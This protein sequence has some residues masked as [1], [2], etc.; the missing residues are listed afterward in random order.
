MLYLRQVGA[1]P[2]ILQLGFAALLALWRGGARFGGV[3]EAPEPPPAGTASFVAA[4]GRLFARAGD[5]P[6]AAQ[7]LAKQA[8]A[9]IAAFHHLKGAP[10]AALASALQERGRTHAAG[11]VREIG[12]LE[13][14]PARDAAGLVAYSRELDDAVLRACS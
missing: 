2:F 12:E 13:T 4:T 7:I 10:A 1:A 14:R 5:P 3:R 11:A 8:L 9:R 6:G